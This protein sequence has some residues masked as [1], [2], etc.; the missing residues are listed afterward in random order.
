MNRCKPQQNEA[1][2]EDAVAI[3]SKAQIV[4][5]SPSWEHRPEARFL[6]EEIARQPEYE[7]GL[8]NLLANPNQF[9]VAYSL[10]TLELMGSRRLRELP[11]EL[12][13]NRSNI[14]LCLGSVRVG[15]DLARQIQKRAAS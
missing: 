12:L 15:M 11:V 8:V 6:A 1:L 3:W 2:L 9:V 14:T 4:H 5:Q 10:I 13:S 7:S